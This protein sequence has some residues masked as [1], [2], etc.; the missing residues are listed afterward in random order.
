MGDQMTP[1]IR[2]WLCERFLGRRS[3][4]SFSGSSPLSASRG[5][6]ETPFTQYQDHLPTAPNLHIHV[7]SQSRTT[8]GKSRL[9]YRN[10]LPSVVISRTN[11][12]FVKKSRHKHHYALRNSLALPA[13]TTYSWNEL[14]YSMHTLRRAKVHRGI[15]GPRARIGTI[16]PEVSSFQEHTQ[17]S[18]ENLFNRLSCTSLA[19]FGAPR[20]LKRTEA[21]VFPAFAHRLPVHSRT[22]RGIR[23]NS[24]SCPSPT[25]LTSSASTQRPLVEVAR[26]ICLFT[27][28]LTRL[29]A[30]NFIM[31]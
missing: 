22:S 5:V 10:Q 11:R 18:R 8:R 29:R 7:Q 23:N 28:Q 30:K 19:G 6:G 1:R 3:F 24:L 4:C 31:D 17:P 13:K 27:S 26:T 9:R 16:R 21:T 20:L 15:H 14:M 2:W 12:L 25:P